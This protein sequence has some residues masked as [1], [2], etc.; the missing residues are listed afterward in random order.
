MRPLPANE[1]RNDVG[2]VQEETIL[3]SGTLHDNLVM[4]RAD[5]TFEEV[6]EACSRAQTR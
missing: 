5:A 6:V 2:V 4:A 3:L 1:L